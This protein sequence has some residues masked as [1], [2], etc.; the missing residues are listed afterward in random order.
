MDNK[1]KDELWNLHHVLECIHADW[2]KDEDS[3]KYSLQALK[4]YPTV[5]QV[6][7]EIQQDRIIKDVLWEF[8]SDKDI[9]EINK[10]IE[11]RTEKLGGEDE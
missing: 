3:G 4:F 1:L 5:E 6:F 8:I 7:T 9:P 11:E 2:Y 10:L